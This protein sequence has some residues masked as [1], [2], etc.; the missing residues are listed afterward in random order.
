[1]QF[2]CTSLIQTNGLGGVHL[3]LWYKTGT[4]PKVP[5]ETFRME[6]WFLMKDLYLRRKVTSTRLVREWGV[7]Q[8]FLSTP[9]PPLSQPAQT[10]IYGR[11][12]LL[13][14]E[15]SSMANHR[16]CCLKGRTRQYATS[17]YSNSFKLWIYLP[18]LSG[19]EAGCIWKMPQEKICLFLFSCPTSLSS[20]V[21][22]Q[23]VS[24]W[25]S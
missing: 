19:P 24:K 12:K 11:S 20:D 16:L 25:D 18:L 21:Q 15:T 1:M 14:S 23:K 8:V 2:F 3:G 17:S 6:G 13:S 10:I 4:Y 22:R 5:I 7:L 9:P